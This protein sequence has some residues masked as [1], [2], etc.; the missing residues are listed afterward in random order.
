MSHRLLGRTRHHAAFA[1]VRAEGVSHGMNVD[2]AFAVV[3]LGDAGDFQVPI[4]DAYQTSR[5]I[6]KHLFWRK[7]C[8]YRLTLRGGL[9]P[10]YG[11]AI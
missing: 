5:H 3:T 8:G 6:E 10:C 11:K 9:T 2:G 1:Q 7:P 4:E